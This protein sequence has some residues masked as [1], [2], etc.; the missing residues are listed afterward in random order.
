MWPHVRAGRKDRDG[1]LT[2]GLGSPPTLFYLCYLNES[3][4]T[5]SSWME[6]LQARHIGHGVGER[7]TVRLGRPAWNRSSQAFGR[8]VA[9]LTQPKRR[10][11]KGFPQE[12]A[13]ICFEVSWE[14]F[15]WALN[16]EIRGGTSPAP[17]QGRLFLHQASISHWYHF[18]VPAASPVCNPKLIAEVQDCE[19]QRCLGV[20]GK[21][22]LCLLDSPSQDP[23]PLRK[24][25]NGEK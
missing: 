23:S 2:P 4:A 18:L 10:R 11:H 17:P 1:Q 25:V 19:R 22:Q 5:P 21:V 7:R 15:L 24:F 3:K 6:L 8:C 9:A 12:C 20:K 16:T 13:M 14:S